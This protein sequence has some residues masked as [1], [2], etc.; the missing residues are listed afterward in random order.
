MGEKCS[1]EWWAF[2]GFDTMKSIV[3]LSED[4]SFLKD[5]EDMLFS[6]ILQV[7]R[8]VVFILQLSMLSSHF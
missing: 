6:F 4:E 8:M 2:H 5:L 7:A 3:D 1:C